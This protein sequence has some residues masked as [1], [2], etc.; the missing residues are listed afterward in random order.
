[1]KWRHLPWAWTDPL[2]TGL[3]GLR[4]GTA[5]V[6]VVMNIWVPCNVQNFLTT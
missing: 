3:I 5:C 2:V 4:L 1:M 6:N